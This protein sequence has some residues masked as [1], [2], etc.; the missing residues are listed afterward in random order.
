MALLHFLHHLDLHLRDPLRLLRVVNFRR[1]FRRVVVQ[2][3]RPLDRRFVV[4]DVPEVLDPSPDVDVRR[5]DG[6]EET[7][8]EVLPLSHRHVH[9]HQDHLGLKLLTQNVLKLR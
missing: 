8:V 6:D 1:Q 2:N 5:N 7:V 3:L 4:D 9:G